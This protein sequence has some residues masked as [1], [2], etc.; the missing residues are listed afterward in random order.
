MLGCIYETK[1]CT[2]CCSWCHGVNLEVGKTDLVPR[3]NGIIKREEDHVRGNIN[4]RGNLAQ[5]S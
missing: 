3:W 5:T 4:T 2:P 1:D